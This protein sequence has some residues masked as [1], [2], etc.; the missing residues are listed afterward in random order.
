MLCHCLIIP[1]ILFA[2]EE[3]GRSKPRR[4]VVEG[5]LSYIQVF[6]CVFQDGFVAELVG[7]EAGC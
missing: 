1:Y 2:F 6:L 5:S 7:V 4:G 3:L